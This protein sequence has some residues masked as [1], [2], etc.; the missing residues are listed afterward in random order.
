M[1]CG[2]FTNLAYCTAFANLSF[3]HIMNNDQTL[4]V[5]ERK[6]YLRAFY[7]TQRAALSIEERLSSSAII[8][9]TL[10]SS[11][12][13]GSVD[14]ICS[15]ASFGDEVSTLD[16]NDEILALN[17][18]L[19]LP[20]IDGNRSMCMVQVTENS[21]YDM[22]EY[23][24]REPKGNPFIFKDHASVLCIMPLLAFDAKGHRLG[25]GGG[26]Y[27]AFLSNHKG[28]ITVGLGFSCQYS[29]HALPV[30]SHDHSPDIIIDEF[31]IHSAQKQ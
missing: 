23:G 20:R 12:I 14:V 2:C 1:I 22:N 5:K 15:Y 11:T 3:P 18:T 17:K 6:K 27:D 10:L 29:K 31:G 7:K 13:L 16:L 28:F 8:S 9:E 26:Y 4:S 24:I 19:L 21:R 25:Y 30:E